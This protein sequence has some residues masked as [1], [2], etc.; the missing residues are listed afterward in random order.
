M[1]S[2]DESGTSLVIQC[3]E[4]HLVGAG[5]MGSIPGVGG[6]HMPRSSEAGVLQLP[7]SACLDPVFCNERSHCTE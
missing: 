2:Q 4:I 1:N 5:D 3:M 6:F 7:K